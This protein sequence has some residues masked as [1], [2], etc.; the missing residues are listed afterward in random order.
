MSTAAET[1][2]PAQEAADSLREKLSQL[3][4]ERKAATT[5]AES[6]ASKGQRLAEA[7]QNLQNGALRAMK[8]GDEAAA[9]ELLQVSYPVEC[10][11]H[12][13]VLCWDALLR[14]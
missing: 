11:Q 3:E 2:P 9:R 12:C 14:A 6:V 13:I 5:K 4:E 8:Q 1:D 10:R 7:V